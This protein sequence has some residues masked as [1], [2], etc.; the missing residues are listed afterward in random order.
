VKNEEVIFATEEYDNNICKG[1]AQASQ[2]FRCLWPVTDVI[3][4]KNTVN[5]SSVVS[6]ED[7]LISSRKTE[8][9]VEFYLVRAVYNFD[10]R[11]FTD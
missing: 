7:E 11:L 5:S 2:A 9:S 4:V 3:A 6:C 1:F 8:F 10:S